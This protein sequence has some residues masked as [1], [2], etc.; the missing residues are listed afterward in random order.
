MVKLL[1]PDG[2]VLTS[3][4]S[5]ASSFNLSTQTLPTIGTYRIV[6]D[7]SGANT[8]TLNLSVTSP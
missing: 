3:L 7:P 4:M 6:V 5:A 8:G 1:K 2:T